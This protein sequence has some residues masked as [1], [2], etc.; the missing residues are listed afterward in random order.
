MK[1]KSS[2]SIKELRGA[3]FEQLKRL[4]DPA[5]DLEK[6]LKRANAITAVGA[7]IVNSI[8]VENDFIRLTKE[9]HKNGQK[10]L[11]NG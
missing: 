3:M 7:V 5:C 2:G 1:S 4:N 9:P 11:G 10:Q 8:R 6:E